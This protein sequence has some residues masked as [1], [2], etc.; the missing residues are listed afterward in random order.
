MPYTGNAVATI[1]LDQNIALAFENRF[2]MPLN[3]KLEIWLDAGW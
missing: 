1:H 3:F 2:F